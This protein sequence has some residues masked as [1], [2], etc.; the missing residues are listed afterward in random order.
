M[1]TAAVATATDLFSLSFHW[2]TTKPLRAIGRY[3]NNEKIMTHA[4]SPPQTCPGN[5][6]QGKKIN[7]KQQNNIK[8]EK[9]ARLRFHCCD[10]LVT[11]G[12]P[13]TSEFG[14]LQRYLAQQVV[15][16]LL[17]RSRVTGARNKKK[18]S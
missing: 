18:L 11:S 15:K 6:K 9:I 3:Q 13:V 16:E 4:P 5:V 17:L 12:D 10:W 7:K 2:K 1:T 8:R 14:A